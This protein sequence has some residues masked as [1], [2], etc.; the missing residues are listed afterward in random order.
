MNNEHQL[1]FVQLYN[2]HLSGEIPPST[3]EQRKLSGVVY[4]H[5]DFL[6]TV[7][8]PPSLILEDDKKQRATGYFTEI[9][10]KTAFGITPDD[11][12]Y[13]EYQPDFLFRVYAPGESPF[14][15]SSRNW[16]EEDYRTF[17]DEYQHLRSLLDGYIEQK[18][19]MS[20]LIWLDGVAELNINYG[21][22]RYSQ[23][24]PQMK[25]DFPIPIQGEKEDGEVDLRFWTVKSKPRPNPKRSEPHALILFNAYLELISLLEQELTLRRCQAPNTQKS[26]ACKNIFIPQA[27]GKEQKYCS[28]KC[29]DR[30][31]RREY[32]LKHGK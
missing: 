30:A 11:L 10:E 4:K 16:W 15:R 26:S 13:V 6:P 18:I 23:E 1:Y 22:V 14:Y 8:N 32:Y 25:R 19:K 17:L 7:V 2:L 20:D 9:D 29:A 3:T 24:P 31:R 5:Y 27:K 21:L 28:K 12:Q